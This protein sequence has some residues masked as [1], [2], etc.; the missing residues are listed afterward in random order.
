MIAFLEKRLLGRGHES[1]KAYVGERVTV[2]GRGASGDPATTRVPGG[3]DHSGGSGNRELD[4]GFGGRASGAASASSGNRELD[5]GSCGPATDGFFSG[6]V[7]SPRQKRV[8]GRILLCLVGGSSVLTSA[9]VLV[10]GYFLHPALGCVLEAVMTYQMLA[11]KC[12]KVESLKVFRALETG[13]L[14]DARQA[15]SMI[16][17]RD[18]DKLSDQGVTKAAVETVA[19]NTSDGVIAPM[20][21][22]AIGGPVLGFFYK[23]VNTMDSMVGYK[24]EKYIDFG[25]CAAKTDDLLNFI[26]SRI[27]AFL[28]IAASFSLGKEFSS[29]NAWRIY[30]RDRMKH[31]SPNSAQTESVCA[32]ALSVRLAGPAMYGGVEEDKP[33]LGDDIRPVLHRDIILANRLLYATAFLCELLC[34]ALLFA[35]RSFL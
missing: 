5:G 12:L 16:V 28:M 18:T 3:T 26:P 14:E 10:G 15:V 13:T 24:N 29:K 34:L 20:L 11:T 7:L 21:Y 27:S 1:G 33:Y 8:G 25:R 6:K 30:K 4:G 32:G 31:E 17:G 19:E 2:D 9:L 22:L 23:A 35:I